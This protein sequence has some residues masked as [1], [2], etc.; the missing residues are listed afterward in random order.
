MA[1]HSGFLF[2]C[3]YS[4]VPHIKSQSIKYIMSTVNFELT[5][6]KSYFQVPNFIHNGEKI[7]RKQDFQKIEKRF[8]NNIKNKIMKS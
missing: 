7:I 5:I 2:L 1:L 3:R 4:A 8:I 6:G